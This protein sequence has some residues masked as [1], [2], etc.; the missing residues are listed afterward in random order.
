MNFTDPQLKKIIK[1][2]YK[3]LLQES[4]A[5]LKSLFGA[6]LEKAAGKLSKITTLEAAKD[7]F[8]S[9]EF[10]KIMVDAMESNPQIAQALAKSGKSVDEL[11]L[12]QIFMANPQMTAKVGTRALEGV[13]PDLVNVL[14]NAAAREA[15][16]LGGTAA[17]KMARREELF[18]K[19]VSDLFSD[20]NVKRNIGQAAMGAKK[21]MAAKAQRATKA[22]DNVSGAATQVSA[23][24]QKTLEDAFGQMGA[25]AGDAVNAFVNTALK[26]TAQGAAALGG[27]AVLWSYLTGEKVPVEEVEAGVVVDPKEAIKTITKDPEV[28]PNTKKK[29][30][31]QIKKTVESHKQKRTRI[32]S[33]TIGSGSRESV[34]QFQKKLEELGYSLPRFGVD[35]DYGGETVQAVRE[36]QANNGLKVDGI[37]GPKTWAAMTSKGAK[38]P[39]ATGASAAGASAAGASVLGA[40]YDKTIIEL[41]QSPAKAV[42][43]YMY[44]QNQLSRETSAR[45]V[46][47]VT[48]RLSGAQ[49]G[50]VLSGREPA[51]GEPISLAKSTDSKELAGILMGYLQALVQDRLRLSNA[52]GIEEEKLLQIIRMALELPGIKS[53]QDAGS[54]IDP[55]VLTR[56]KRGSGL[57]GQD[58]TGPQNFQLKENKSYNIDFDKW[59]KLW[60]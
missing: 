51:T 25:E 50:Y 60:K 32:A 49:G 41:M 26:R 57:F 53:V 42:R 10:R 27:I 30:I 46:K 48:P 6:S 55:S 9:P 14:K 2:E 43:V 36:F 56:P 45:T 23:K 58:V 34:K 11:D 29:A 5:M 3:K 18:N 21:S 24:G 28:D 47:S 15:N 12:A 37:V 22:A 7:F 8:A 13:A 19:A 59:S 39:G 52:M 38:G 44:V 33:N 20:G 40:D 16:N 31:Q 17:E 54:T 35:G 1:E 4:A